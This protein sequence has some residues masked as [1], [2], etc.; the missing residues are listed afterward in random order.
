MVLHNQ[1]GAGFLRWWRV[2]GVKIVL[3]VA[4]ATAYF[5]DL[6]VITDKVQREIII[7]GIQSL[8]AQAPAVPV[9]ER[10]LF[11]YL[12]ANDIDK[13]VAVHVKAGHTHRQY[14]INQR[15]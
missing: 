13:T 11:L 7:G 4:N 15:E 14:V 1:I 8:K 2:L 9:I 6:G 3:P 12:L 5:I 10:I